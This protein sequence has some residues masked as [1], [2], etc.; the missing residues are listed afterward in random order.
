MF[1]RE[2]DKRQQTMKQEAI[3]RAKTILILLIIFLNNCIQINMP[4]VDDYIAILISLAGVKKSNS[5]Q[6]APASASDSVPPTISYS[7]SP[8]VL[9]LKLP[10]NTITPTITG[11]IESCV[12]NPTLPT[13]LNL[14]NTTCT[15][16]G[17]P[18]ATQSAANYAITISNSGG[19]ATATISITVNPPRF[20]VTYIGNSNTGGTVP[21]DSNSYLQGDTVTVKTNSGNLVKTGDI[22][23]GWNTQADG[24]GTTYTLGSGSF[25]MPANNV[26]LWAKWTIDPIISIAPIPGV[27]VPVLG[28]I[29]VTTIT[30]TSQYTGTITWDGGWAWS[31]RFGGNKVY[32]ATITLTPK[33]GYT[34]TGV[35]ANFFTVAGAT[36]VTNSA[37]SGVV[38]AV[39][40]A[41][42]SVAVADPALGGKV[43]Y[44]LQI[45]DPG[46]VAGEQRGLIVS[47][48]DQIT[49][50]PI[51]IIW[52]NPAYQSTLVPGGTGTALGTGFS[53]TNKIVAQNGAGTTY[54][55]G[56]ARACTDGGY[57]DWF[58]PSRDELHKLWL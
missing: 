57:T 26:T 23:S 22:I 44:I 45:G 16:S 33:S 12:S 39:F 41:T 49:A 35:S 13:G 47:L 43:A 40:P 1:E 46:Y 51:G 24:N 32:T 8:Y 52:A 54:A 56:L 37:N 42:A 53:N 14:D 27:T 38:T 6:Q 4:P 15:I 17:T 34:F 7:G 9:T 25:T 31:T 29:P 2:Y 3:M 58:L 11:T 55:A 50:L 18:T 10:I 36:T 20:T 21:T 48:A 30:D 5:T 19:N 28:N